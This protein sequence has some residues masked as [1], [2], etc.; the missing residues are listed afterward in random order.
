[1]AYA[2]G[3]APS[4]QLSAGTRFQQKA[5]L[6]MQKIPFGQTA[7][8]SSLLN[9]RYARAMGNACN[10]NPF[11]LFVPCHRVIAKDGSIGGFAFS[12]EIKRRLLE[13]EAGISC[14]K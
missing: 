12:L 8:Y 14:L 1:L 7:S 2:A 13:F 5:M 3:T 4:L 6:A 11:P 9:E 10:K